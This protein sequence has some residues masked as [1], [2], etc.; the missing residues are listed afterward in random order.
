[1]F[2]DRGFKA[3]SVEEVVAKAGL[4]KGTFYWNFESKDDLFFAL[5]EERIDRPIREV[6]EALEASPATADMSVEAN[7]R[8]LEIFTQQ[9]ET[10]LL[11]HEYWALAA[12]DPEVQQRYAER[13]RRLRTALGVA[14]DARART[15]GAP[16]FALPSA[17]VAGAFLAMM[18]GLSHAGLIDPEALPPHLFGEMVATVYAGMVARASGAG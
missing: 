2:A 1:V 15:L 16:E 18:S 10:I 9:R 12:R 13:Q 5:V 17:E 3:A 4:S 6:I 7:R 11:E 14:L 8:F